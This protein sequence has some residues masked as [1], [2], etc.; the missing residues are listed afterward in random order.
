MFFSIAESGVS[1]PVGTSLV[2]GTQG[3][4]TSKTGFDYKGRDNIY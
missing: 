3:E 1:F 4:N 2:G